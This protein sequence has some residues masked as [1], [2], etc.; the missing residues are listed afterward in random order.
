AA[1]AKRDLAA[2][3]Q[4]GAFIIRP[5]VAQLPAHRGN[6]EPARVRGRSTDSAH[7]QE[8]SVPRIPFG[9]E[10]PALATFGPLW[11]TKY[12]QREAGCPPTTL[13]PPTEVRH[14]PERFQGRE[15]CP[16]RTQGPACLPE[17]GAEALVAVRADRPGSH[18]R[19]LPL[20]RP[21]TEELS[22]LGR[23]LRPA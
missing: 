6:R 12:R 21:Q 11:G 15:R 8:R 10:L 16:R 14:P 13:V 1:S 20:L 2:G 7:F 4:V 18:R 17:A 22:G 9:A 19:H 5:A 3:A 23:A